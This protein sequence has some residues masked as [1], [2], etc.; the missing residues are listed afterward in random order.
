MPFHEMCASGNK[1]SSLGKR[2]LRVSEDDTAADAEETQHSPSK[3]PVATNDP[4]PLLVLPAGQCHRSVSQ[5]TQQIGTCSDEMG[6]DEHCLVDTL[7][8]DLVTNRT[9]CVYLMAM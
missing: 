1:D 2:C 3:R 9:C 6:R 5:N 7:I 8:A 4:P